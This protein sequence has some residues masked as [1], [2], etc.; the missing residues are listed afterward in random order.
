MGLFESYV[1][2]GASDGKVMIYNMKTL[3]EVNIR[4]Q[5]V[6]I[7]EDLNV[8]CKDGRIT[9]DARILAALPTL[10]LALAVPAK[11]MVLSHLGRPRLQV[12]GSEPDLVNQEFS[13]KIVAQ[14]LAE[15][16]PYPVKFV[17]DWLDGTALAQLAPGELIVAENVRFLPGETE[18]DPA[19]AKQ[20]AGICDVFVMDAFAAAHRAHA[21]TAGV[22]NFA[23]QAVA[24]PLLLQEIQA[25]QQVVQQPKAPVVAIVGGAK[26]STKLPILKELLTKVDSLILGGGIA[27]TFL[28]ACGYTIGASLYEQEL[29]AEARELLA[30]AQQERC[31]ILLPKDVVVA[32]EISATALTAIKQLTLPQTEQ[33]SATEKILDVGPKTSVMYQEFLSQANTILWNGPVGVFE[34]A[35]FARGTKQLALAIASNRKAFSVA[36]GGDT[37]A[38][39]EQFGIVDKLSFVSTGG[40]AFLEYIEGKT[41]PGIAALQRSV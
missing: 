7:R 13:L 8:P 25:L 12:S 15:L 40:G 35:P 23:K 28:V 38:A 31:K 3:A 5:R 4:N 22:A 27:N 39:I 37:L 29:V 11:V 34:Y 20:M 16:L 14:R 1:R 33:I 2:Y 9:N 24:G 30:H 18:N 26:V 36:G 32:D 17:A 19:L 10:K 21:S 6:L 41:L